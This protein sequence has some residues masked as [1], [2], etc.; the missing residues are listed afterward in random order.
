MKK[1]GRYTVRGQ[2]GRGG[3]GRVYKV[4]MPVSGKIAA[5]KRLEPDDMLVRLMG[6]DAIRE[7]FLS[8]AVIMANLRHPSLVDVW[9][10][11]ETDGKPFY[12]MEY[13]CNNLGTMIGETYET[14]KPSRVL[15]MDKAVHY[16]RQILRGLGRL[17]HAGIIH[18]DIKPFNIL[19]TDHDRVKISDFG[20][21]KIR[22]ERFP[23]LRVGTPW[24][25]AP[26]QEENPD[27]VDFS[28]DLFPVGVTLY[29]MLTGILPQENP[30]P[31]GVFNPDLNNGW[32]EFIL[33]SISPRPKDRF[34]SARDM[35]R[36]LD[37]LYD[38]W[39]S[40]QEN[41]CAFPP[42]DIGPPPS[43]V[44][45]NLRKT[46]VKVR[47]PEA[48]NS[49]PVDELWRPRP[50]IRNDFSDDSNGIITDRATGLTWEQAGSEYPVTWENACVHVETLNR[51]QYGGRTD[52]RLPT[53][54]ELLSLVNETPHGQ[55]LCIAPVFDP[56]QRRL[57]SCDL[58]SHIAAWYVNLELGFV[59]W[60]D[61]TGYYHV[62]GVCG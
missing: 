32:N 16:T 11:D 28:A 14:E 43:P 18:R 45:V 41:V 25:A 55:A 36:E 19:L 29:R 5:L 34:A 47:P 27:S 39:R 46:P 42:D 3:M 13:Y 49:F 9:D 37:W 61:F 57:W 33:K 59:A 21:S 24:Y 8:E 4:E 15:R 23:N 60:Q 12:I 30:K 62:R 6:M 2:L 44:P 52:W 10:V 56:V 17:H 38:I 35:L 54:D 31:P 20:L 1:I 51:K 22:G 40:E 26:E 53:V 58:R 50:Y 48:K 7:L